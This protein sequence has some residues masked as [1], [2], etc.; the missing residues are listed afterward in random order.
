MSDLFQDVDIPDTATDVAP[1]TVDDAL[2]CEVCGKELEYSG[3]GRKPKRC[4]EHK[5]SKSTQTTSN[6]KA[7]SLGKEAARVLAQLNG[8]VA[9]GCLIAPHPWTLPNTASAIANANETFEEKAA[10]ALS[11]DPK[12]ARLIVNSG[13]ASGKAA[14]ILAYVMLGGAVVPVAV[15]EYR[16]NVKGGKGGTGDV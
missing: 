4:D 7:N 1:E 6:A 11:A 16:A 2:T 14:L 9:T 10:Q 5:R 3:R 12:L 15:M 13:A 8:L